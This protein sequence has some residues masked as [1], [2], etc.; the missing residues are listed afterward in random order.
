M[1]EPSVPALQLAH[2]TQAD[3][4]PRVP[5][6]DNASCR[7][8]LC[9]FVHAAWAEMNEI[10]IVLININNHFNLSKP[11]IRDMQIASQSSQEPNE[12]EVIILQSCANSS[13]PFRPHLVWVCVTGNMFGENTMRY[14]GWAYRQTALTGPFSF[15]GTVLLSLSLSIYH[16][17]L[18]IFVVGCFIILIIIPG[19]HIY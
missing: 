2:L 19:A 5:V 8:P 6:E 16:L 14:L 13:R 10:Y 9:T 17:C 1:L 15:S 3:R 4:A 7:S 18:I 11:F 12:S